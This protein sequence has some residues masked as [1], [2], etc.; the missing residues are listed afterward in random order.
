M[1]NPIFGHDGKLSVVPALE[2]AWSFSGIGPATMQGIEDSNRATQEAVA[3]QS[4]DAIDQ[5][6]ANTIQQ[7]NQ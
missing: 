2:L 1:A 4:Q 5:A 3:W 6:N 7:A